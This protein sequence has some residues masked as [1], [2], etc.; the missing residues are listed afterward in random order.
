MKRRALGLATVLTVSL[1]TVPLA[2]ETQQAKKTPLIGFL[3]SSGNKP[4]QQRLAALREGLRELGYVEGKNVVIEYR[5]AEGKFERLPGFAAELV[6]LEVDILVTEGTPAAH[7]A[8]NATGVI[9]I[10]I[11]NAGD[12]VGSGLVA[13]LARPGANIT[14]LSDF[15][16]GAAVKRLQLLKEMVPSA[17]RVA[18]LSNPGN[19]TNPLQLKELEAA[20]PTLRVTLLALNAKNP[21]DIDRAFTTIR[22]ERPGALIVLGDALF[23]MHRRRIVELAVKNRIPA[24]YGAEESVDIGGL[25]GYGVNFPDLHRRAATYVDKILKGAKPAE[26]PIEQPTKLE[27]VVNLKTAKQLGLTVPQSILLRADRVIQ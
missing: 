5:S 23:G 12:P 17:S 8:K 3:A 13:S 18:V 11:G 26:L 27:L 9:P 15:A 7:A 1:L 6:R 10:V 4:L 24:I 19:S 20:A 14:G 22:K 16:S 21:E 25:M 2:G